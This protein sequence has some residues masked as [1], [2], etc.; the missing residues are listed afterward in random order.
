MEAFG[1]NT[2]VIINIINAGS[3]VHTRVALTGI[4]N[5][6]NSFIL[7]STPIN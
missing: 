7:I 1:T 3:L 6:K 5:C 4:N 2:F